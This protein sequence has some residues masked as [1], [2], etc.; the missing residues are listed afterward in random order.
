MSQAIINRSGTL[1]A[2]QLDYILLDGSGSMQGKW[3]D[4][5]AALK[6]FVDVLKSQNINSHGILQTFDSHDLNLVQRDGT[7]YTWGDLSDVGAHWGGTPLYDAI[8]HMGLELQKLAPAN[9][10]CSIVIV[11]D[12][13]ENGSQTTLTQAKAVL[14][15]CRAQGWQITF[16]G[17]DF[18]NNNQAKALGAN[19]SHSLGVRKDLLFEAG[20]WLGEKRARHTRNS[21]DEINFSA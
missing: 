12:G 4:T 21:D 8:V 3:W 10:K 17:A 11:T 20:K 6:A 14:D 1:Q 18:N 9:G 7:L 5:M 15:W 2:P 16:L 19:A 13:D